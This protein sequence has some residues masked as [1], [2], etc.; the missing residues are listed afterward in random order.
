MAVPND[1]QQ[2]ILLVDDEA[3]VRRIAG[4]IL[5]EPDFC[6]IEAGSAEKAMAIVR[7][8][9]APG[10]SPKGSRAMVQVPRLAP[11]RGGHAGDDE[12][13][14][15]QGTCQR[16]P[17]IQRGKSATLQPFVRTTLR[18]SRCGHANRSSRQGDLRREAPCG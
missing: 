16:A 7:G 10:V 5:S 11:R 17:G 6:V 12:G 3:D 2:T 14:H 8:S 9:R 13:P 1:I 4:M 18:T 15:V